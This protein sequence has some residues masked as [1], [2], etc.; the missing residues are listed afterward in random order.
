[1][2]WRKEPS[3]SEKGKKRKQVDDFIESQ[4]GDMDKFVKSNSSALMNPNIELAI[5]VVEEEKPGIVSHPG[6]KEQ[7]RV[8]LIHAPKKT[9]Y[10]ITECIEINVTITSEYS[11]HSGSLTKIKDKTN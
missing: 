6:F 5:V 3:D 11:L 10:I 8:H 4:R 7:R 9:T 1:M 2:P